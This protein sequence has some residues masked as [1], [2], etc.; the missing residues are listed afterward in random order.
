M[1]ELPRLSLPRF[2]LSAWTGARVV[3]HDEQGFTESKHPRA[4]NGEFA[5]GAGGGSSA[6]AGLHAAPKLSAEQVHKAIAEKFSA[7]ALKGTSSERA[8]LRALLKQTDDLLARATI[9]Q[10]IKQSRKVGETSK[11]AQQVLASAGVASK[12]K[13]TPEQSELL[14]SLSKSSAPQATEAELAQASKKTALK[15]S[16]F[17]SGMP[18]DEVEKFDAKYSGENTP[19]TTE[20]LNE[21]VQ[22]FKSLQKQK[23]ELAEEKAAKEKAHEEQKKAAVAHAE[24]N[25]H[26][27]PPSDE[28][29]AKAFEMVGYPGNPLNDYDVSTA[30]KVYGMTR[31]EGACVVQYTGSAY[32]VMNKQLRSGKMTA[33]VSEI[34]RATNAGLKKMPSHSG[35]VTRGSG[36]PGD[37]AS[38]YEVGMVIEERGFTSTTRKSQ[39]SFGGG[40]IVFKIASRTGK[41]VS[42]ISSHK[43]EQEVLFRSGS[44]FRV[45][46][47]AGNVIHMEEVE[48]HHD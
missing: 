18:P 32:A 26:K 22:A 36:N 14:A 24:A 7:H 16:Q 5:T 15:G 40:D 46:S 33:A 2:R 10:R 34:V 28:K 41:D 4:K 38:Y 3:V 23:T 35:V 30:V 8:K 1:I 20:G 27:L 13:L 48:H 12:A 17:A 6:S 19:T 9:V 44:R 43:G 39:T 42:E 21:K 31:G 25:F 29:I 45:T 11:A 37:L 47:K